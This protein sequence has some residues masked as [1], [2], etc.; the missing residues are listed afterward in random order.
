MLKRVVIPLLLLATGFGSMQ[1]LASFKKGQKRMPPRPVIRTVLSKSVR[2]GTLSPVI[3]TMG[4]I[5]PLERVALTPEVSGIILKQHFKLYKGAS[6]KKN[7]ILCSID[8]SQVFFGYSATM[9]DLQNAVASLI[10]EFSGNTPEA[11]ARWQQFFTQLSVTSVPQLPETTSDREKLLATRYNVYKLYYLALQQRNMLEKHTLYAP[12]DGTVETTQIYPASMARSGSAVA[13]LIRTDA[14][15]IELS[16]PIHQLA[17][18][19]TGTEVTITIPERKDTTCSGTLNR[20]GTVIDERMQTA[21][22][23]IHLE[24]PPLSIVRPGAYAQV[25]LRLAP[26]EH[27]FALPRKALYNKEYVY[28]IDHD[29]LAMRKISVDYLSIDSAY[30]TSGLSEGAT[31]IVEP[32][33]DA[34]IGMAVQNETTA[35]D[36]LKQAEAS[37]AAAP[38]FAKSGQSKTTAP[39]NTAAPRKPLGGK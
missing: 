39:A 13:S 35:L 33:Q 19:S 12:F 4:R 18:L 17:T 5:T 31:L 25:Q 24:R 34:V 8:S 20:I 26:L 22:V 30:T 16:I 21:T 15:E 37:K 27:A 14:L 3:E 11:S 6:F 7:E 10:P 9:S 38:P 36:R 32:L 2:F 28:T 23:F 1:I 29:T